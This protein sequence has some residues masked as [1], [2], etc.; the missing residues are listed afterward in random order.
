MSVNGSLPPR[1]ARWRERT[2]G[3]S[4]KVWVTKALEKERIRPTP[5]P[6]SIPLALPAPPLTADRKA[7][8]HSLWQRVALWGRKVVFNQN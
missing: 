4:S 7:S 3:K 8:A 6:I 2:V 1:S 5:R